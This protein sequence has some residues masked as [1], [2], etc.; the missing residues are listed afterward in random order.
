MKKL[1]ITL[2]ALFAFITV[3]NAQV[4]TKGSFSCLRKESNVSILFDFSKA[5]IEKKTPDDHFDDPDDHDEDMAEWNKMTAPEG[6]LAK[7]F[8]NELKSFL[9]DHGVK[10]KINDKTQPEHYR[11]LFTVGDIDDDCDMS[12]DVSLINVDAVQEV[13]SMHLNGGAGNFGSMYNL[14]GDAL[15]SAA[16][17][18]GKYI[19]K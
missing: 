17:R 10:L 9:A 16:N 13:A 14:M 18:F 15:K 6:E 2:F 7:V 4:N 1:I 11:L 5:T 8:T 12:F 19:L 3:S